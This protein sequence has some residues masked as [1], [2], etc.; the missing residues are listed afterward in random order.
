MADRGIG[1]P[2]WSTVKRSSWRLGMLILISKIRINLMA[3]Q[4]INYIA[5]RDFLNKSM[6]FA[7]MP[8]YVK[9]AWHKVKT[10][11]SAQIKMIKTLL[12]SVDFPCLIIRRLICISTR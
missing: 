11:I 1:M 10:K 12:M 7:D 2:N 5:T 8:N 6:R 3:N 4:S 9:L